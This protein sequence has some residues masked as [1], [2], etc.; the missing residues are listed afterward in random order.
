MISRKKEGSRM[1]NK[2][3]ISAVVIILI[4]MFI[5]IPLFRWIGIPTFDNVLT[6]VLG[7]P[8]VWKGTL[9]LLLLLALIVFFFRIVR[10]MDRE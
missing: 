10:R 6:T 9:V 7:E 1:K 5:V 8:T 2:H 4:T 3:T